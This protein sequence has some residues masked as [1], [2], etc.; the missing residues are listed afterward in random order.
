MKISWR[1]IGLGA[2]GYL[3][4]LVS[5]LPADAV[6][7]R[8]QTRGVLA[9][10][11]SGSIWN[12]KVAALQIGG[13]SFGAV[14]WDVSVWHFFTGQLSVE[15]HAKR[16]DGSLQATLAKGFGKRL[17]VRRLQGVQPMTA[18]GSLG[19]PGGWDGSIQLNLSEVYLENNWPVHI[20]GTAD[21][22]N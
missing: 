22:K 17:I 20:R 16:D 14:D 15:L 5:T 12:G 8:L 19:L 9:S 10:G 6:L 1:L 7:P 2:V 4:F 21:A 3:I 18:L 13:F 11:V